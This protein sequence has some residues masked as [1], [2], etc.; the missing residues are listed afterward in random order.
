MDTPVCVRVR[1]T[2]FVN[3]AQGDQGWLKDMRGTTTEAAQA[4]PPPSA[5]ATR[6]SRQLAEDTAD[7]TDT[8]TDTSTCRPES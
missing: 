6:L 8:D 2:H 4:A 7:T 5:I 1:D 3:A